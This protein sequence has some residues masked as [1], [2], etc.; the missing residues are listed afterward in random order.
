MP[1]MFYHLTN[2]SLEETAFTLLGR[3]LGADWRVMVRG[4]AEAL[5]RLDAALWTLHDDSFLPHGR[6]GGPHDALQP[7]LLGEGAIGNDANCLMVVG[8]ADFAPDEATPLERL[9]VLFDGLDTAALA[10]ARDQW[11]EVV[12]AGVA[13]QYWSEES[14]RWEKKAEREGAA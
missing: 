11:R 9:W 1:V 7:V 6:E 12:S 10:R 5:D 13:A 8:G 3:A 2:S 4:P 14:G